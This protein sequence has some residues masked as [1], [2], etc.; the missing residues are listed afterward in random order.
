M[1]QIGFTFDDVKRVIWTALETGLVVF[2]AGLNGV[3]DAFT[4]GG[5]S[6][7]KAAGLAL[8]TA[9]GAAVLS[10]LKNAVLSPSASIK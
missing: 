3:M 10:A 5:L 6:G 2:L 8:V 7:G 4:E 1:F 9:A